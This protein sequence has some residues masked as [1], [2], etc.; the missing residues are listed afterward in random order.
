MGMGV[1]TNSIAVEHSLNKIY[2]VFLTKPS[3]ICTSEPWTF[4]K[5]LPAKKKHKLKPTSHCR[6]L[7]DND[8]VTVIKEW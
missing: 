5:I 8:F 3:I 4:I 7:K 6:F 1:Q 2:I